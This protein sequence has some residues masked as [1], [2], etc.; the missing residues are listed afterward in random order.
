MSRFRVVSLCAV[1]ATG[2]APAASAGPLMDALRAALKYDADFQAAI[3]TRAVDSEAGKQAQSLFRPKVQIQTGASWAGGS[4]D[5]S[6]P[7]AYSSLVTRNFDGGSRT[8]SMQVSQSVY[9][10]GATAQ[11]LQLKEKARAART[12]FSAE[13]QSLLLKVADVVFDLMAAD[14]AVV[15]IRSQKAALANEKARAQVRFDAGSA[16][17][18]DVRESQAQYDQAVASE[19]ALVAQ[20]DLAAARYQTV[21]GLV[22]QAGL[23][24]PTI[25]EPHPPEVSL[26]DAMALA[27]VQ[28]PSVV[29]ASH[30]LTSARAAVAQYRWAGRPKVSAVGGYSGSWMDS[31]AS[32]ILNPRATT[33]YSVGVQI[34]A[35]LITGGLYASELRAALASVRKAERELEGAQR[36]ARLS[37]EQAWT[38]VTSGAARIGALRAAVTSAELQHRAAI[39]GRDLNLRTQAD[40]L[41]AQSQVYST[42]LQLNQATYDYEKN[43]LRLAASAGQ[44]VDE[45]IAKIDEDIGPAG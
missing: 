40:V 15:L 29:G 4:I 3:E 28:S 33:N 38:G 22:P 17:I 8:A 13:R 39:T 19:I 44:L 11:A 2:F 9:D 20:R 43:R 14:D 41:T 36:S 31:G 23:G 7:Q 24:K 6:V 34:S 26:Q 37:A 32:Q 45:T 25:V 5:V 18:T 16:K 12:T 35:P 42:R 10:A 27:E 1:F 21:T 30:S